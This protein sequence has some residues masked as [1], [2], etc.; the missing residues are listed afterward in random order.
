M[1]NL[2]TITE[3]IHDAVNGFTQ[4]NIGDEVDTM[5]GWEELT[6]TLSDISHLINGGCLYTENGEY[7]TV[8]ALD[9]NSKEDKS[10]DN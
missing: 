10:G 6:I 3:D 2:L 5:W 9:R 1:R 8:I 4:V 7:A